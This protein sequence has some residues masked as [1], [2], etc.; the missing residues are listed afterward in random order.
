MAVQ[1]QGPGTDNNKALSEELR[2]GKACSAGGP[3]G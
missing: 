3:S 2:Q 1:C